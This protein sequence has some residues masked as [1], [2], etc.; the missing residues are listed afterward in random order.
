[1]SG[2][3]FLCMGVCLVHGIVFSVGVCLV[4]RSVFSAWECV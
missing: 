3:V 4:P 2:T 1:M